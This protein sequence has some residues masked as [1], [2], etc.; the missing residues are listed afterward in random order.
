MGIA[1]ASAKCMDFRIVVDSDL[2]GCESRMRSSRSF[3]LESIVGVQEVMLE[4]RR[5]RIP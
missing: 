1:G 3:N 2:I 5:S 4:Y